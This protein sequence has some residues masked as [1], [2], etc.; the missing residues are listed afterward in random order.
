MGIALLGN[1]NPLL[2]VLDLF[3]LAFGWVELV[4]MIEAPPLDHVLASEY[5]RFVLVSGRAHAMARTKAIHFVYPQF[6]E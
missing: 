3:K 6:F 5:Y 4:K 2:E 1:D